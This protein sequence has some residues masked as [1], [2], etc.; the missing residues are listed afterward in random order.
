MMWS[1]SSVNSTSMMLGIAVG[2]ELE[3]L[4][5]VVDDRVQAVLLVLELGLLEPLQVA[6]EVL[7]GGIATPLK[8]SSLV[9]V[10]VP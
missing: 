10:L 5:D 4:A 9:G 1:A 6:V 3:E 7:L 2:G 8:S